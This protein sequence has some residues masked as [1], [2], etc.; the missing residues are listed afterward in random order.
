M[1]TVVKRLSPVIVVSTAL[2][3]LVAFKRRKPSA[4]ATRGQHQ[5]ASAVPG[6]GRLRLR[7]LSPVI[8]VTS[9]L[10][11]FLAD[12]L[13]TS[14]AAPPE[15]GRALAGSPL[16]SR[17]GLRIPEPAVLGATPES[18]PVLSRQIGPPS[19]DPVLLA[20]ARMAPKPTPTPQPT[21]SPPGASTTVNW[22]DLGT[23]RVTG[24]SDSPFRNGTDG[25]GI[26]KS[27]TKTHWGCVAVDPRVIPLGTRLVIEDYEDTVF[28]A[29]DTGGG[30]RGRWID[31]WFPNDDLA[32]EHGLKEL[33]VAVIGEN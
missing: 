9:V 13:H 2:V 32:L 33:S 25:R 3:L 30:I 10:L 11:I 14:P 17:G 29:L 19:P 24:Y 5:G 28:T 31:I 18:V 23:F 12:S 20:A 15:Y 21:A 26:T 22:R 8:A 1:P 16:S 7:H 4:L 6:S 27:G